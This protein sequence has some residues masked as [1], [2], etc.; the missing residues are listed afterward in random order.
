MFWW[1]GNLEPITTY[2]LRIIISDN[3]G[4]DVGVA[5]EVGE[6]VRQLHNE[7][8]PL[9]G[10]ND[11]WG[12]L[13]LAWWHILDCL[14]QRH[15]P[16]ER[17]HT[18]PRPQ[19]HLLVLQGEHGKRRNSASSTGQSNNSFQNRQKHPIVLHLPLQEGAYEIRKIVTQG[20]NP[21]GRA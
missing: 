3:R 16:L 8:L 6:S 17:S 14:E 19:E 7:L 2:W 15:H 5:L 10:N 1:C 9:R 13:Q 4:S 18:L 21:L 12:C 11:D 20:S